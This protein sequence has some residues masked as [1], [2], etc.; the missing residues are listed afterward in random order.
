MIQ[1]STVLQDVNDKQVIESARVGNGGSL[2]RKRN[3][4][5]GDSVVL[6][7]GAGRQAGEDP[8]YCSCEGAI[9]KG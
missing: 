7:M 9:C 2:S 3:A 1:Y 6:D 8:T 4:P 5:V